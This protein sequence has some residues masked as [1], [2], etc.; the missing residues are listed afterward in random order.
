MVL[1][2]R[3]LPESMKGGAKLDEEYEALLYVADSDDV[4][5]IVNIQRGSKIMF[6]PDTDTRLTSSSLS[7][8]ISRSAGTVEQSPP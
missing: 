8:G 3:L 6:D 7:F 1:L 2:C 5:G 4:Y